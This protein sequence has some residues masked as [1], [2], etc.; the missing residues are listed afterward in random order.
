[1]LNSQGEEEKAQRQKE[2]LGNQQKAE[3]GEKLTEEEDSPIQW[4]QQQPTN[5]TILGILLVGLV[6]A[7]DARQH[8]D[9]PDDSG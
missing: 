1:M 9:H 5:A 8:E 3:I 7:E 4:R 6:Q 2:Q